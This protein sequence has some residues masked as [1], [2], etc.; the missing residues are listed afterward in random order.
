MLLWPQNDIPGL[1]VLLIDAAR[2][3][4]KE[5]MECGV[6]DSTLMLGTYFLC[7]IRRHNGAQVPA[8]HLLEENDVHC[9]AL[10]GG[11]WGSE[12]CV[13]VGE[14]GWMKGGEGGV[15]VGLGGEGEVREVGGVV[16]G[17]VVVMKE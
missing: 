3:D 2:E 13:E 16:V 15:W 1:H 6:D 4:V 12:V 11:G 10:V 9:P 7:N 17:S 14:V 8:R 5:Q